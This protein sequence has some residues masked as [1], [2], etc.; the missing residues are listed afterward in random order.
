MLLLL[1][2]PDSVDMLVNFNNISGLCYL[3][4][5]GQRLV[6]VC[7]AGVLV[8]DRIGYPVRLVACSP[9]FPV[10]SQICQETYPHAF[11]RSL[12]CG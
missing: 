11:W 1:N 5:D 6:M 10:F 2:R 12:R 7:I 9:F 4:S 3:K 8:V